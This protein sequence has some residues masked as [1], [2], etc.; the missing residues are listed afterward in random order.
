[1]MKTLGKILLG[2]VA[3]L[4]LLGVASTYTMKKRA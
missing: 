3:M 4:L 2:I 1:M